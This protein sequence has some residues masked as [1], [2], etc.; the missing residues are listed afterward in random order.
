MQPRDILYNSSIQSFTLVIHVYLLIVRKGPCVTV[1]LLYLKNCTG[2][3]TSGILFFFY[4]F[5]EKKIQKFLKTIGDFEIES[6]T[7]PMVTLIVLVSKI[8]LYCRY[9]SIGHRLKGNLSYNSLYNC[10]C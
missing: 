9:S 7:I 8:S 1:N 10:S 2:T 4:I 6:A 5:S 3:Y